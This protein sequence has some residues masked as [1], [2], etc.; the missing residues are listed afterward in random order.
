ML[1][2]R[3]S[4]VIHPPGSPNCFVTGMSLNQVRNVVSKPQYNAG[5]K[6]NE[7]WETEGDGQ[8]VSITTYEQKFGDATVSFVDASRFLSEVGNP[9][10]NSVR[11]PAMVRMI[12]VPGVFVACTSPLAVELT[13]EVSQLGSVLREAGFSVVD[14][15]MFK[16]PCYVYRFS[17]LSINTLFGADFAPMFGYASMLR[18]FG[19]G[20]MVLQSLQHDSDKRFLLA[21][22]DVVGVKTETAPDELSVLLDALEIGSLVE[23]FSLVN[24]V[25][26][27]NVIRW[28]KVSDGASDVT[29]L[30]ISFYYTMMDAGYLMS[31]P[32]DV[33]TAFASSDATGR[34][35]I[36]TLSGVAIPQVT[37]ALPVSALPMIPTLR[38]VRLADLEAM[39]KA[40]LLYRMLLVV[41][42]MEYRG[43][44]LTVST[45]LAKADRRQFFELLM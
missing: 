31:L 42:F 29:G 1:L 10:A 16:L 8:S 37:V 18:R 12:H 2:R 26:A 35:T 20:E 7:T 17:A 38:T 32:E 39:K 13:E 21:M 11:L 34:C 44:P 27:M 14:D 9:N 15:K 22:A 30:A 5:A 41:R 36:S 6:I 3:N 45:T 33:I 40:R 28:A 4:N 25:N 23:L 43:Y 24:K 19:P